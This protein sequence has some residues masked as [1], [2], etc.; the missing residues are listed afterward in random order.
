[1]TIEILKIYLNRSFNEKT[2][3]CN[4]HTK[5]LNAIMLLQNYQSIYTEATDLTCI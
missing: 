2:D 5:H 1:M 4:S 3:I